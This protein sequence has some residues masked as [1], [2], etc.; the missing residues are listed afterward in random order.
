M[1]CVLHRDIKSSNVLLD[2]DLNA[3]LGDFGLARLIDH[4]KV[5]KT[6]MMAGTLGYMAPEMPHTG[7]ATKESDVYSFG[8][9]V[10]EVMCGKRPLDVTAIE[11]GE[12]VLVD[13]VWRAHEGGNILQVADSKLGT[14]PPSDRTSVA[15][16]G[17]ESHE[18]SLNLI[19]RDFH[20]VDSSA[21]YT[22]DAV[23]EDK[24][25]IRNMLQLGLLCCNPNPEDRPFM[26][27]VSQL[28]QASEIMETSMPPVPICKPHA[29]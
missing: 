25:M 4:Q 1:Q 13:R 7:K 9:L 8:V 19:T 17:F 29:H 2:A 26:R 20:D 15:Y 18:A 5:E 12:G 23:M 10:L 27:L 22:P 24:K 3:Y 21:I 11:R 28:L 6:T 16:G 14:F